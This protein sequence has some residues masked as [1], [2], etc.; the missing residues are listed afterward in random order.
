MTESTGASLLPGD[1]G[2]GAIIPDGRYTIKAIQTQMFDYNGTQPEGPAC[3]IVFHGADG[4]DHEQNY[5]AGKAEFLVP[6]KDGSEFVH[7]RGETAKITKG[8]NFAL[9]VSAMVDAGFPVAELTSKVT[10]FLGADVEIVNKAQPKR[11]GLKDSKEGK[12]IPLPTKYYGKGKATARPAARPTAAARTAPAAAPS[13]TSAAPAA[14]ATA[15]GALDDDA[16]LAVQEV[17]AI[18]DGNKTTIPRLGTAVMLTLAK[19]KNPNAQA[20]RKMLTPEWLTAQSEVG[21]WIVDGA[22][23]ALVS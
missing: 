1:F 7:P 9:F 23:I 12:T 21:S 6:N 8:S 3:A 22:D 4:T 20:I 5:S 19:A 16:I 15:N 14:S 18:A 17:L 13:T 2:G 11:E 10:A